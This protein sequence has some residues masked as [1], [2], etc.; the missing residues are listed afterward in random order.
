MRGFADA[1]HDV[2][3]EE[4]PHRMILWLNPSCF[5]HTTIFVMPRAGRATATG[6]LSLF[7]EAMTTEHTDQ[8]VGRHPRLQPDNTKLALPD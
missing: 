2:L 1:P 8:L 3:Y 6:R 5:L 4:K 7:S